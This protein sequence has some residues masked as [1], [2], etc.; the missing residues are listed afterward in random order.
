MSILRA[1]LRFE[2]SGLRRITF[3]SEV[4]DYIIL[5]RIQRHIG[6]AQRVGS[7]VCDKTDTAAAADFDALIE[8]LR[9]CHGAF[10]GH[11]ES[12]R[13]FLLQRGGCKRRRGRALLFLALDGFD[14]ER[15][16][17]H[18]VNDRVNLF[19]ASELD[20]LAVL[21]VETRGKTAFSAGKLCVQMPKFL[22]DKVFYLLIF[23]NHKS[24]R[25]GLNAPRGKAGFDFAPKQ[26]REF[27]A[28]NP[29]ENTS[30]LLG[31]HKIHVNVTGMTDA[32]RDNIFRY[33]V[34]CDALRLFI[35]KP[36]KL[37]KVPRNGFAFAVRVRREIDDGSFR[38][39]FF[40]L[41][42]KLILALDGNILGFEAMLNVN[43][44]LTFRQIPQMPHRRGNFI[45]AA[46]VFLNCLRFCG[47]FDD[48]KVFG[49]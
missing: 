11:V 18:G 25:Y 41:G 33:F 12:A 46:Q 32:F 14:C 20:F 4:C 3:L 13:R 17:R 23:V 22:A 19:A 38:G 49:H 42:D 30:R 27:V 6:K 36:Q 48:Y 40:E 43:A 7:H 1:L 5:R 31:I 8:L 39:F 10:R 35:V 44:D 21:A 37:L 26:R 15:R 28:D 2:G 9:D 16:R 47:G 24:C 45:S 34:E 29:V